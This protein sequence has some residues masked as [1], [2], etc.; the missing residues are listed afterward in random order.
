MTTDIT[1]EVF[2]LLQKENEELK[3]EIARLEAELRKTGR[4]L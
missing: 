3:Q 1:K 2:E 4:S